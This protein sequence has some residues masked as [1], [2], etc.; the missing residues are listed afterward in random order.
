MANKKNGLEALSLPALEKQTQKADISLKQNQENIDRNLSKIQGIKLPARVLRRYEKEFGK[1]RSAF[2]LK[3][4]LFAFALVFF[5]MLFFQ[6]SL[7]ITQE[8][9][10]LIIKN[11]TG[12]D[13]QNLKVSIVTSPLD[14]VS[15]EEIAFF[16]EK[17]KPYE[18]IR[19]PVKREAIYLTRATRQMPAITFAIIPRSTP[20]ESNNNEN[21]F[22]NT[23]PLKKKLE[24]DK[25]ANKW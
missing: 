23:N 17:F 8:K 5:V 16:S 12:R 18:E 13:L 21:E 7:T 6:P 10:E 2:A 24:E 20:F 22:D 4:V 14:I 15:S 25:N 11:N 3:T 1:G 9:N 19:L